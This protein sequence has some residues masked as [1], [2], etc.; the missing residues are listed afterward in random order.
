MSGAASRLLSA[1]RRRGRALPERPPGAPE[2]TA[3]DHRYLTTL[4]DASVPLPPGAEE[5]LREDNPRLRELRESYAALDLP[6]LAPS[7]WHREAIDSFLDLRWFRGESLFMW[8]Y[9]ELRR[10]TELKYFAFLR[11]VA[12]RDRLGLLERLD[13]DGAFGC[14]TFAYEGWGRVSRDLLDSVNELNFL[15]REL[16]LAGRQRLRVL[17]V[18]AGYGRLAHRAA[19]SF[20]ALADYCCVDAIPEAT[21]LSDYYLRHRGCAPPARVVRLDRI[22][23]E[24]RPGDFDLAVNVHSFSEC[25]LDAI[26]W[27]LDLLAELRVPRLFV[28]PNDGTELLSIESDGSRADFAPLVDRAGYRLIRRESEIEDPAVRELLLGADH[29][30]LFELA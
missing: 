22:G 2:L 24:L 6:V 29:F 11:Y 12:D 18:G 21:F 23:S 13:E 1:L 27:W 19:A 30:H 20:P 25:P 17:D 15:E 9:R 28:V 4:Y 8:H 7:H 10:I 3:E 26:E 14:W 5:E 16:G